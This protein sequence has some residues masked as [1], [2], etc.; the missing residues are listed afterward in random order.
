MLVKTSMKRN[1]SY[2]CFESMDG[3]IRKKGGFIEETQGL[4]LL[5]GFCKRSKVSTH[6]R[7]QEE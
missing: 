5:L 1:V 4:Y 2:S 3:E 6:R 7:V